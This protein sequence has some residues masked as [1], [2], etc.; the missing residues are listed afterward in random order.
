M[1]ETRNL[2]LVA[3]GITLIAACCLLASGWSKVAEDA[4]IA[5]ERCELRQRKRVADIP[6]LTVGRDIVYR[7]E[8]LISVENLQRRGLGWT[9]SELYE[10]LERDRRTDCDPSR[11]CLDNMVALELTAGLD[12]T[13]VES[14]VR[15][16]WAAGYDIVS[17]PPPNPRTW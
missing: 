12:S 2:V 4:A 8:V 7:D 17:T 9:I 10:R 15:T 5:T 13:L 1:M 6:R 16:A 3:A 14:I 11:L